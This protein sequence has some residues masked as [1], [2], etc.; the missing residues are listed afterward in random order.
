[1]RR[2]VQ[3]YKKRNISCREPIP[4]SAAL[5]PENR[6]FQGLH[7]RIV[8]HEVLSLT[9]PS[10]ELTMILPSEFVKF[11]RQRVHKFEI[12]SHTLCEL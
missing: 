7:N 4:N 8:W 6:D 9:S 10:V 11:L 3:R 5:S 12:E 2:R 1:M